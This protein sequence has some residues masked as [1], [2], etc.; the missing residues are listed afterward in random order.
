MTQASL[1][2]ERAADQPVDNEPAQPIPGPL[3]L[4]EIVIDVRKTAHTLTAEACFS[5]KVGANLVLHA[6]AET[7]PEELVS[8]L[9]DAIERF[10]ISTVRYR[11]VREDLPPQIP[12]E[13]RTTSA[14]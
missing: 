4:E 3:D 5:S 2:E 14:A 13:F 6:S 10:G 11:V 8:G 1:I 7:D 12:V 9:I